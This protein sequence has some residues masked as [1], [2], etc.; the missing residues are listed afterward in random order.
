[1]PTLPKGI[2]ASAK[3]QGIYLGTSNS[4]LSTHTFRTRSGLLITPSHLMGCVITRQQAFN[5]KAQTV[6]SKQ[7]MDISVWSSCGIWLVLATQ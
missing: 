3:L 4:I 6:I 7:T 2:S 5:L 1:M